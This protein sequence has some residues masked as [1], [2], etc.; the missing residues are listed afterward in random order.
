MQAFV[1]GNLIGEDTSASHS[2]AG[3]TL[4]IGADS[5]PSFL[6][7]NAFISSIRIIQGQAL[8]SNSFTPPS[9]LLVG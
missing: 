9:G 4:R 2:Y 1:D 3:G 5:G 8:Y 7:P 6:L